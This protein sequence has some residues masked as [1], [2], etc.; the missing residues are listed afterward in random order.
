MKTVNV[1]ESFKGR[2]KSVNSWSEDQKHKAEDYFLD[3][4]EKQEIDIHG[5]EGG[6]DTYAVSELLQNRHYDNGDYQVSVLSGE[7]L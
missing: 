7:M 1:V 3:L 4:V 5:E 2:V 6:L